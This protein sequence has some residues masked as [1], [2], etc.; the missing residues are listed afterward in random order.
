MSGSLCNSILI[1]GN[2]Q[3]TVNSYFS[4]FFARSTDAYQIVSDNITLLLNYDIPQVPIPDV[5]PTPSA[6]DISYVAPDAPT[7]LTPY[8][9]SLIAGLEAQI[10]AM[11]A[12]GTGMTPAAQ[13]ALFDAAMAREDQ[14]ALAEAMQ[15]EDDWAA[16][17]WVLPNGVLV[18]RVQAAQEAAYARKS[19]ASRDIFGQLAKL[20]IENMRE[21]IR[22]GADAINAANSRVSTYNS[23]VIGLYAAM[24]QGES[25]RVDTNGK[26]WD[27]DIKLFSS[28]MDAQLQNARIDVEQSMRATTM[29]MEATKVATQTAAQ[30]CAGAMAAI[31]VSA[32]MR[33]DFN[34]NESTSCSTSYSVDAT[35]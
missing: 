30:V 10:E 31:N 17:G 22:I 8:D 18:G 16:R 3:G 5:I 13:Q 21:S 12:G 32:G 14:Q 25:A 20:E 11:I 23:G 7:L 6:S 2:V 34:W 15:A 35:P 9:L 28:K 19:A 1:G 24:V 27:L 26:L 29:A 33:E 4:D